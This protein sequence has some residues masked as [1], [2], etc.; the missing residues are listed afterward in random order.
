VYGQY[1]HISN[2]TFDNSLAAYRGGAVYQAGGDASVS[3]SI[4]RDSQ[5]Y[6]TGGAVFAGVRDPSKFDASYL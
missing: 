3:K 6:D 1:L 4:F 2:C 5:G